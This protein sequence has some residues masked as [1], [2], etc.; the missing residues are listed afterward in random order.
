MGL[1]VERVRLLLPLPLLMLLLLLL[2]A[3]AGPGSRAENKASTFAKS[4]SVWPKKGLEASMPARP[5]PGSWRSRFPTVLSAWC[6]TSA[7]AGL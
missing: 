7:I 3:G 1:P 2:L 5:K 4:Y 6:A